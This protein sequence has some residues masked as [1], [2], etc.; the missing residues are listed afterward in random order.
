MVG[1]DIVEVA[2]IASALSRFGDRFLT[3]VF[4]EG[5]LRYA[6][7]KKNVHQTLAGRFAAKEAFMKAWGRGLKWTEIDVS[8]AGGKPFILCRGVRYDG[9]SISHEKA[10]AV[11]VV[12]ILSGAGGT[13]GS[14]LP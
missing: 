4:T 7:K 5:E 9:V 6:K 8:E 12:I 14:A 1:V 10:Y 11:S 2:R 13:Y 3:K